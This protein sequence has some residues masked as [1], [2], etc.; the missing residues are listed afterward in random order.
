MSTQFDYVT[1]LCFLGMAGAFFTL[2]AWT[3]RTLVHLLLS[4]VGFAFANQI[5][6]AGYTLLAWI[7]IILSIAYAA[8]IIRQG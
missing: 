4:G 8:I 2:T 5:G 1:L 7:L 3:P 6:N